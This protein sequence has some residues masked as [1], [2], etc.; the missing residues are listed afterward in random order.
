MKISHRA[1]PRNRSSRSSRPL[2]GE[3]FTAG[4]GSAATLTCAGV[5]ALPASSGSAIRSAMDV[6]WNRLKQGGF[7]TRTGPRTVS[8][9]S[10]GPMVAGKLRRLQITKVLAAP[11][12]TLRLCSKDDDEER[13]SDRLSRPGV[14][15]HEFFRYY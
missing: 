6:I 1:S 4:S 13:S 10:T 3:R 9:D 15:F 7:G 8:A 14:W 12:A 5:P 11:G 2:T